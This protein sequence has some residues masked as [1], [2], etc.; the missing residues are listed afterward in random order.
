MIASGFR[1]AARANA[2]SAE[3]AVA[4]EWPSAVRARLERPADRFLVIDDQDVFHDVAYFGLR[5]RLASGGVSPVILHKV[6]DRRQNQG[7]YAP[8]SP[9]GNSTRKQVRPSSRRQ[10]MRPP[11]ASATCRAT[12]S[13]SPTP[14][15]LPVTNGSNSRFAT[16]GGGP[17]PE[18]D[19]SRTHESSVPQLDRDIASWRGGFHGV[20]KYVQD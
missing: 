11:C 10:E 16:S 17:G 3:A 6:A 13:P 5:V 19:T 4:A 7:A 12:A 8:R 20:V 9:N 18:S 15:G 2:C 14:S 1:L